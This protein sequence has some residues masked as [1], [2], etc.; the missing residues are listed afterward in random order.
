MCSRLRVP[1]GQ[2]HESALR[3]FDVRLSV[4]G[5][6]MPGLEATEVT[7]EEG[8]PWWWSGEEEASDSFLASMGVVLDG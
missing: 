4:A 3:Q 6:G 7:R 2:T 5:W 1:E 8:A